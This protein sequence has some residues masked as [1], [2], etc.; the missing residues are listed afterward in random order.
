MHEAKG[1]KLANSSAVC[2]STDE[3]DL[4]QLGNDSREVVCDSPIDIST[5]RWEQSQLLR[6]KSEIVHWDLSYLFHRLLE[7]IHRI[8]PAVE[9]QVPC[10]MV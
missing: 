8:F 6:P 3:S 9:K 7:L 10:K 4:L 1:K 2:A 5:Q